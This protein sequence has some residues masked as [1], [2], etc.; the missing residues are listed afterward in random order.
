M[1]ITPAMLNCNKA[2]EILRTFPRRPRIPA[3][4]TVY[5]PKAKVDAAHRAVLAT[6]LPALDA[7]AHDVGAYLASF[8][9]SFFENISNRRRFIEQRIAEDGAQAQSHAEKLALIREIEYYEKMSIRHNEAIAYSRKESLWLVKKLHETQPT[10]RNQH[11]ESVLRKLL[12]LDL[13][14]HDPAEADALKKI[15]NICDNRHQ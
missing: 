9:D 13:P 10:P 11:L 2:M 12:V 15:I 4:G 7:I 8:D 5:I 14:R 1:D 3:D 6:C